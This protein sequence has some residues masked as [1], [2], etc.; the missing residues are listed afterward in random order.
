MT[1]RVALV[2]GAARGQGRSHAIALAAAGADVIITD[3]DGTV[4]TVDYPLASPT[5]LMDV[6]NTIK[7]LG[8]RVHSAFVDVRDAD[9]MAEAVAEGVR[10]FGRLDAVVAN[11]GILGTP[12][13][14]WELA[15][16]QWRTLID[17]NLTGVW[18]TFRAAIPPM[19]E[20]GNGGS[21]VA[22]SS[23]AG[24]RGIPHCSH[25]VAAKH[26][27][28][29]L[30]GSLAN[31]LAKYQIRA[32][33]LHPTNVRTPMIDNPFS[34]KIFRPDLDAPTLEDADQV[35]RRINLLEMP[36]ID[37][38]DVTDAVMWLVSDESKRVTGAAIPV[39]AGMLAKY[40]G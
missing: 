21:L 4:P 23:I 38:T 12:A 1:G 25:Y 7:G 6:C 10:Q 36:W 31:E 19:I 9:G 33:T 16:D 8:R 15:P 22:I 24:L 18:T 13:P 32:N 35:L 11:A 20:A 14:S 28:V 39:D 34:A 3:L 27:V 26:G 17:V 37:A 5:D 2:T 29:G 30:V 40:N